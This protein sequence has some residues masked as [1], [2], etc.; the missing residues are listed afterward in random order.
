MSPIS[1]ARL[2]ASTPADDFEWP[3]N[4]DA[5]TVHELGPDPWQP[6]QDASRDVFAARRREPSPPRAERHRESTSTLIGVLAVSAIVAAVAG[7]VIYGTLSR[8]ADVPV[9]HH[10]A[11]LVTTPAASTAT[12]Q[13]L[14]IVATYPVEPASSNSAAPTTSTM[15]AV[16]APRVPVESVPLVL[17][18]LASAGVPSA[19]AASADPSA[20][21][22]A[23]VAATNEAGIR[24]LLHRYED[25]YDR[26]D[27]GTAAALWPS[28]DQGALARA[29]A[30]LDRQD[31]RF[32]RCDIDAS[33]ARGS[34]VCVGTLR[35]VP[36]V[37]PAVE[38][39]DRITWTF[40]LA[41]SGESWRIAGLSAR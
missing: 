1:S 11:P 25:A 13:R 22:P 40:D 3:P 6:L 7:W 4:G 20:A 5:L 21:P 28:L 19:P 37:G 38:R 34:A 17:D 35:Y 33:E 39:E 27:V 29:F 30:S 36:S 16:D 32:D 9:V 8:P 31:V 15:R 18:N 26:R 2:P 12:P 14:T 23:P 41:R 24:D 10:P